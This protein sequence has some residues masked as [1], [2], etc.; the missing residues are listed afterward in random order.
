MACRSWR[1]LG[2]VTLFAAMAFGASPARA[3]AVDLELVLAVDVSRSIDEEEWELQRQG[4][5]EAFMHPA[6]IRAIQSNPLQRI[7][8]AYVEWGGADYQRLV[9]PWT[10]VSDAGSGERF[11][12][13]IL[14]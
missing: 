10:V 13:A 5:A 11:A 3:E 4:Y 1:L 8:V 14:A 12:Q 2:L 6:V 9:I 7:A